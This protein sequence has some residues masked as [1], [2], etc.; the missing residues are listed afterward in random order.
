MF[1]LFILAAGSSTAVSQIGI[2]VPNAIVKQH[3]A[4]VQCQDENFDI[5]NV[6][7]QKSFVAEVESAIAKCA[8]QKGV[9]IQESEKIL[10]SVPDYQDAGKRRAAI[11]QSFDGY[12]T[13]RREMARAQR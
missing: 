3:N 10:A 9:L 4:Y 2:E 6:R 12:D 7:D 8:N 13:M 11:S 1:P 5:S